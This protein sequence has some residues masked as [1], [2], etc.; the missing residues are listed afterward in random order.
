MISFLDQ[1][2]NYQVQE[3]T[4]SRALL[5]NLDNNILSTAE[6]IK[7]TIKIQDQE[8]IKLTTIK[9]KILKGHM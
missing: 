2:Q 9:L 5:A 6:Q 3:T 8:L 4:Q 7:N 1:F